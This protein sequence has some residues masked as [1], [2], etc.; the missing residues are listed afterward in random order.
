MVTIQRSC[1]PFIFLKAETQRHR[2]DIFVTEERKT[3]LSPCLRVLIMGGMI[4]N[5]NLRA[6][7]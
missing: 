7:N 2:E 5:Y 4:K 1:K 3:S 6:R